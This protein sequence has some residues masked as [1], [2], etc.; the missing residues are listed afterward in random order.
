M[1]KSILAEVFKKLLINI[2]M[3][4][5]THTHIYTHTESATSSK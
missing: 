3:Y 5:H 1:Q 2:Y 4:T